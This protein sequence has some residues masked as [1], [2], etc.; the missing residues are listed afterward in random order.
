VLRVAKSICGADPQGIRER[1]EKLL[2]AKPDENTIRTVNEVF[3]MID[4][5]EDYISAWEYAGPYFE[6]GKSATQIFDVEFP[7]EKGD[8]NVGWRVFPFGT[9][10]SR[11]WVILLDKVLG[12]EERVVYLRTRVFA[13]EAR[14]VILELGTNDGCKV[15]FNGQKIHGVNVGRPLQPGQDKL[16]LKLNQGWNTIMLAVYQQGGAWSACAR[17]TQP[18]GTPSQGLRFSVRE[19]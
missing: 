14:D 10:D 2:V 7:P 16:P 13:P 17:L 8:G 3:G 6:E 12:G 4:R 18:N 15:W 19:K 9:D 5:F 11:G 1:L